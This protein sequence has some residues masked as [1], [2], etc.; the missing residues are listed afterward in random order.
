MNTMTINSKFKTGDKA[1]I[2]KQE[3]VNNV[4][5]IC[6]GNKK[7]EYKGK[8]MTCP[9]CHGTGSIEQNKFVHNVKDEPYVIKTI[10]ISITGD[11]VSV[12]YKGNCGISTYNRAEDNLYESKEE[13]QL[14]CDLL[15][16]ERKYINISDIIAPDMFARTIPSI[17]KISQRI[18]EY[19]KNNSFK[20]EIVVDKDNNLKDGYSTYLV[21]K[22]LD[23]SIIKAIIES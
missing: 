21:C 5:S 6:E 7:I 1:Y 20:N 13:A 4:C 18:E 9:E 8:L 22:M 19:K 2:I 23:V 15:D 14:Q 11:N 17:D 12:S 10:K 16:R 3:K